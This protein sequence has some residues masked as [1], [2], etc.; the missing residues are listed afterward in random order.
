MKILQNH[1]SNYL[2]MIKFA[3]LMFYDFEQ[4]LPHFSIISL[5]FFKVNKAPLHFVMIL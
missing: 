5:I 4:N 3:S 2:L 1:C